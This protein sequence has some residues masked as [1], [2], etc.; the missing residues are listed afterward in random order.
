MDGGYMRNSLFVDLCTAR[1]ADEELDEDTL[2]RFLG[3]Y[4]VGSR[5]LYKRMGSKVDPLGPDNILGFVTGPLTGTPAPA[6][7]RWTVVSKSP[8]TGAWGDANA[9]GFF[10]PALKFSGYD[11]VFF[12]GVSDKPVYLLVEN[13]KAALRDACRLWGKDCYETEDSLKGRYGD[14]AQIACI[15]PAAEKSALISAVIHH[16]GRAAGR[17]GLGAVM[18]AK[19]LKAVVVKGDRKVPVADVNMVNELRKKYVK[20]IMSGV[21]FADF[22]RET[23]TPGAI[24]GSAMTGDSPTKNWAGVGPIDF[25]EPDAI[26]FDSI[27]EHR[28]ERKACWRCPIACWGTVR[29]NYGSKEIEAHQPEYQTAAAFGTN[30]LNKDLTSIFA[31]N[32]L[33]NRYGLDSIS[34]GAT[35]AFAMECY[36]KGLVSREDTDGIE[37]TWG[38]GE[39]IVAMVEKLAKREGFGD[40]LA[41]GVKVAAQRIGQ[42]AASYAMHIRGQEL[43]MHDPRFEPGLGLIYY[44]DATPGRHTQASQYVKHP[45]LDYEMPHFGEDPQQQVGRGKHLKVISALCHVANASGMCL[46]GYL[47]TN[48]TFLPEFLTAVTGVRYGLDDLLVVGERIANIRQAFNVREGIGLAAESIPRRAYGIP[49][50]EAGPTAGVSVDIDRLVTEYL[51]EMDWSLDGPTPS[52]AKLAELG[53]EDVAADLHAI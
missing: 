50:L 3:G 1:I 20:E 43:P 19:R 35:I 42:G 28:V 47:S 18:G 37:L 31:A 34:A 8:L 11:A 17:S 6:G 22:Y 45:G 14:D 36:E 51:E 5:I 33:C 9:G 44:V 4:G 29:F 32:D 46:F 39:A 25:P 21:G 23:G 40:V 26:G 2:R 7:A 10:G 53:L 49:P 16:K 48:V 30:C 52:R 38:N 24:V 15:G 13:G 12:V 41:D 27:V